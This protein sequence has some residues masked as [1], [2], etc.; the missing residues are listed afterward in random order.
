MAVGLANTQFEI[1]KDQRLVG[2]ERRA[3]TTIAGRRQLAREELIPGTARAAG[4]ALTSRRTVGLVPA[5]RP[6]SVVLLEAA[7]EE[8]GAIIVSH[9]LDARRRDI[10]S[11]SDTS[12]E[13]QAARRVWTA[14]PHGWTLLDH[15]RS[16]VAGLH[17]LPGLQRAG[18]LR[19]SIE[20]GRRRRQG[21]DDRD[22][23]H[24]RRHQGQDHQT[25]SLDEK[26]SPPLG[27]R[28]GVRTTLAVNM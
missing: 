17:G 13:R 4:A 21:E 23:D 14:R 10:E 1:A 19:Q 2:R 5:V 26:R 15:Q 18:D 28:H 12:L 24:L 11:A 20:F 16:A 7:N 6:L 9:D 25:Q 8:P 22:G 3:G 27:P